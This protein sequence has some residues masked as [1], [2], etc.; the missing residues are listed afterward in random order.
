MTILIIEDDEGLAEL[1]REKLDECGY[2]TACAASAGEAF[3]WLSADTPSIILLDYSLPDMNA[4]EFLAEL[5]RKEQVIP[6]F[7]ISTGRGDERIAVDMMKLGARDYIVKES[8]FLDMLPEVVRR[9]ER[10]IENEMKRKQA[11]S[12]LQQTRQNYETFFNT[13]DDFLFVLDEQG[14]IIHT[15]TPVVDRLGYTKEELIGNPVLMIHP[16]ERREEAGRIVG[17]MLSG[18]TEF[19]P[20]PVV[21]K[22]GVQIPVETRISHGMWNGKSAI[23]GVTKDISKLKLSEE[24]F[25]KLFYINPSACGLS[26]FDDHKYI[27]VNEAFYNLLGFGRNEVIG[28]TAAELGILNDEKIHTILMGGDKNGNVKNAETELKAKNG[29]I[30]YV[31]LSSENINL[32]DKK[33]RFT[34]VND[35]TER[36]NAEEKVME[37]LAEKE[38]ILKEVHHRIKNNMNTIKSLLFLQADTLNDPSAVAALH[39]AESRVESMMILY[40]KLYKSS[41]FKELQI[42]DYLA[43][44]A[45]EIIGNFPNK[46]IVKLE[47]QIDDFI[48]KTDTLFPLGILINELLTNIMKYA[49]AGRDNGV[50]TLSASV[51]DT[52]VKFI[53][54]DNGMGIPE[55]IDFNKGGG[56]GMQLVGM[57]AQQIGGSIRIERGEGAK[58]V[59][60]FDL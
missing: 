20:V 39:D 1:I 11:E 51:K 49:F 35:I 44:L 43:Q 10:E 23:F 50:I 58:F 26:G 9:V 3:T 57:L 18:L 29:D 31:L 32:Q 25:S 5:K 45:D 40:D 41:D 4:K 19:C 2:N 60:E 52:R 30:K 15:N 6:S 17:E 21:T 14:N 53:I 46:R 42:K 16:A 56:F 13:I 59:L 28:K 55:S 54:K 27:E 48:I 12:L 24:K 8:S 36:K 37:L 33:Y 22:S 34:I 38:L 47:K 7:I